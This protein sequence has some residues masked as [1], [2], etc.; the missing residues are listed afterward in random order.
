LYF[1]CFD[2]ISEHE[3]EAANRYF[4]CTSDST[5]LADLGILKQVLS[6]LADEKNN[7]SCCL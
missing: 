1:F 4:V 6:R 3:R 5:R 2:A 7:V